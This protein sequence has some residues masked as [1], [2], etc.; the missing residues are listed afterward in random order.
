MGRMITV[1]IDSDELKEMFYLRVDFATNWMKH[2]ED[3]EAFCEYYDELVDEGVF[4]DWDDFNIAG[5]VDNDVVNE[6]DTYT[7]EEIIE[8]FGSKEAIEDR[9]LFTGSNGIILVSARG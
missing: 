1:H 2:Y 3:A 4:D 7:E 6:I 5:V 8:E 9:I